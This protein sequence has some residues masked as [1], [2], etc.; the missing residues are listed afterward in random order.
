[1]N[2]PSK[3]TIGLVF[4]FIGFLA[5]FY[6]NESLSP[7]NSEFE[8]QVDLAVTEKLNKALEVTP[9]VNN[10]TLLNSKIGVIEKLIEFRGA[11]EHSP[12]L[13]GLLVELSKE[14]RELLKSLENSYNKHD[15][16]VYLSHTLSASMNRAKRTL[17]AI[18]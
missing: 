2:N 8:E 17:E 4:G 1:M 14:S 12:N 13:V 16:N 3:F 15:L 5:G 11:G 9:L 7:S 6:L 18:K 10:I